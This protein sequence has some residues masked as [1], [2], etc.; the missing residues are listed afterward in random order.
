M[1]IFK[2]FEGDDGPDEEILDPD[3]PIIDAHHHLWPVDSPIASFPV[4]DFLEQDVLTGHNIVATVFAECMA[5]Y[6][7]DGDEA[8]KPVGE[9]EFVVSSCPLGDDG[10]QVAA[11]IIG[12]ADLCDPKASAPALDAHIE[13][14]Q[15]RFRG[16]RYNVYWHEQ[17]EK[18]T[19]GPRTFPRHILLDPQFRAGLREV[20]SRSLSYDVYMYSDQLPELA[21]TADALPELQFVLC[22]LGGPVTVD[23]TPQGRRAVFDRWRVHMAAVGKRSNIALKVGGLG[24]HHFGFGYGQMGARPSGRDLASLWRDY[25]DVAVETFGPERCIAESN[26]PPDKHGFSY[27]AFWNALKILSD[28]FS[29]DERDSL[30]HGAACRIYRLD[31][32]LAYPEDTRS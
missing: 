26:F 15:G 18:L 20:A 3:L 8:L 9:T 30:F 14:G 19:T 5:A 7:P 16:V 21:E 11:G 31:S 22:H 1:A 29:K 28:G 27:S 24:L 2:L 10:P 6:R 12:F 13:A 4:E 17:Q 25:F 23:H 32:A